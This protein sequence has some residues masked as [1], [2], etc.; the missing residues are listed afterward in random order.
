MTP[1][2]VDPQ[3]LARLFALGANDLKTP[4]ATLTGYART[5]ARQLEG[6]ETSGYAETLLGSAGEIEE[7]AERLALVARIHEGRYAPRLAGVSTG[8]LAEAAVRAL[9]EDR[10]HVEGTGEAVVVDLGPV[11]DAVIACAR[12]TMRHGAI[13]SVTIRV[14]GTS[15]SFGP[16]RENARPVLDGSEMR[17]FGIG[18][19]LLV[20]RALGAELAVEEDRFVVRLPQQPR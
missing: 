9:G 14:S 5:L 18:A 6:S 10:V 1:S 16:V 20:L 19:A 8:E 7:I 13:D 2:G 4:L 17:E 3:Q 11:E 15:L 12:A